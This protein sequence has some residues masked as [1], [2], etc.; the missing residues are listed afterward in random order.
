MNDVVDSS[1]GH[2]DS[3]SNTTNDPATSTNSISSNIHLS[4]GA[5]L[6]QSQ[7]LTPAQHVSPQQ[8]VN[9]P[10]AGAVSAVATKATP[11]RNDEQQQQQQARAIATPNTNLRRSS[12]SIAFLESSTNDVES[13]ELDAG[14]ERRPS[15]IPMI[16]LPSGF[17]A[18][19]ASSHPAKKRCISTCTVRTVSSTA[20]SEQDDDDDDSTI[21]S[22]GDGCVAVHGSRGGVACLASWL[23]G[24]CGGPY[25]TIAKD[26]IDVAFAVGVLIAC[27]II[28]I[29]LFK[30]YS[31]RRP[32]PYQILNDGQVILDQELMYPLKPNTVSQNGLTFIAIVLPIIIFAI[33][34]VVAIVRQL[35]VR[36]CQQQQQQQ[37]GSERQSSQQQPPALSTIKADFKS[38]I[39]MLLIAHGVSFL[40]THSLKIFVGRFRPNFYAMCEFS[41]ETLQC[42][43]TSHS[44]LMNS[45]HSFPSGHSS[46]SFTGMTILSLYLLGKACGRMHQQQGPASLQSCRFWILLALSPM[47]IAFA[48]AA[49]RLRD[50]MHHP[51]DVLT[52]SW[53]GT[54]CGIVA[55]HMWYPSPVLAFFNANQRQQR[56]SASLPL[57]QYIVN[58]DVI[59]RETTAVNNNKY[60]ILQRQE[61]DDV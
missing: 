26:V 1:C 12:S 60:N 28:P 4:N 48:V 35:V 50:F 10:Q 21:Q 56:Q 34:A 49:S 30:D 16:P 47:L 57:E 15:S 19:A 41:T 54:S 53:I 6:G 38:S 7:P 40:I 29:Q 32:I 11:T 42:E 55:Y 52:G 61:S 45:Q 18:S 20:S 51:S 25:S 14:S 22:I 58:N 5:S 27:Q 44:A 24:A 13:Q 31:W 37:R 3:Y 46:E 36:R 23:C 33:F 2:E 59:N 17:F 9:V 8:S 39:C 43:A